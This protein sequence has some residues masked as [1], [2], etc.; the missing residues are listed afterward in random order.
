MTGILSIGN[1]LANQKVT[2]EAL[3]IDTFTVFFLQRLHEALFDYSPDSFKAPA[4]NSHL[5]IVELNRIGGQAENQE[6]ISASIDSFFLEIS[7]SIQ[8]D[9]IIRGGRNPTMA[10]K[11]A[12]LPGN[13][14]D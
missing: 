1:T 4:L 7:W 2:K 12:E 3:S 8:S 10:G 13:T 6:F 5:R 14:P 9:P 11:F